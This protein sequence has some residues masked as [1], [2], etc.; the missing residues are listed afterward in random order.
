[1][2]FKYLNILYK[3]QHNTR[4]VIQATKNSFVT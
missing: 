1:M 3:Y 2:F 4:K